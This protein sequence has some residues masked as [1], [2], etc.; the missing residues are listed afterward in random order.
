[1]SFRKVLSGASASPRPLA[2]LPLF[3][4]I[5]LQVPSPPLSAQNARE[6][7][8]D[9]GRESLD[10]NTIATLS[11]AVLFQSF[12][13]IGTYADLLATGVYDAERVTTMLKETTFYLRNSR[14]QLK[15]FQSSAAGLRRGDQ[16][17][18]SEV[19]TTLE[20]LITE[21]ESLSAYALRH[22]QDDLKRFEASKDKA[23][24]HLSGLLNWN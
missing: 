7:A 18:L 8:P 13:Y 2:F 17:Y 16:R 20:L 19:V 6:A 12:G 21:A 1:M 15:L 9:R 23:W 24:T 5:L 14:D 4:F 3:L 10:L 11:V 22:E